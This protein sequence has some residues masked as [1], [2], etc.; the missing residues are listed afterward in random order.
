MGGSA[1]GDGARVL[2]DTGCKHHQ[3][4]DCSQVGMVQASHAMGP[5]SARNMRSENVLQL[6][7]VTKSTSTIANIVGEG[8]PCVQSIGG[9][10][11]HS[12]E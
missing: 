1:E 7:L 3:M 11:R 10:P 4:K 6:K 9:D 8:I 12:Q 5:A 2:L